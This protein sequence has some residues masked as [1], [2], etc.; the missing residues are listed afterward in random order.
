[1]T[2]DAPTLWAAQQRSCVRVVG[3]DA[4]AFLQSQ[5][6]Q[7]LAVLHDA[8]SCWSLVLQPEG[9]MGYLIRVLRLA[10]DSWLLL[11]MQ[12]CEDDLIA[13]LKRFSIRVKVTFELEQRWHAIST[14]S[15]SL[16]GDFT[17]IPSVLCQT[18]GQEFLAISEPDL[19]G[20]RVA[21]E[22]ASA[23]HVLIPALDDAD[24]VQ[25]MVPTEL[26]AATIARAVSFT[27]G[28]Y[29][30]QELVARLDARA[31]LPPQPMVGLESR[32]P[33]SVGA[34]LEVDGNDVGGV[35]RVAQSADGQVWRA[36][37]SLKRS[38]VTSE[39]TIDRAVVVTIPLT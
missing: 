13:R 8:E 39:L 18:G 29:P 36:L 24:V 22:Q 17:E 33:M 9:R 32:A 27:K 25:D 23:W 34:S 30:G 20:E 16:S 10:S 3:A 38:A 21:Y 35:L 19:A 2:G 12:G 11:G 5:L 31:A 14:S 15:M 4:S 7:D 37:A 28:C 1:M 6:S 26:G